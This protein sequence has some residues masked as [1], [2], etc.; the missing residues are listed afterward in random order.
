MRVVATIGRWTGETQP[1]DESIT[2]PDEIVSRLVTA[3]LQAVE[4]GDDLPLL[5]RGQVHLEALV[6][7][8]E[9]FVEVTSGAVVE[10]WRA[11]GEATQDRA[12]HAVHVAA[13]AADQRLA[14][15]GRVDFHRLSAGRNSKWIRA[16][17]DFVDW[18]VRQ[19]ELREAVG[20]VCVLLL[21]RIVN[22][23]EVER[24]RHRMIADVRRVVT[25]GAGSRER[26]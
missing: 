12:F 7:E 5:G 25:C 11:G 10:V 2:A 24:Q 19:A 13:G 6:V 26:C 22:E 15:I 14:G 21:R 1:L 4:E 3:W 17:V 23:A 18:N 16:A 8:I 20:D 9:N